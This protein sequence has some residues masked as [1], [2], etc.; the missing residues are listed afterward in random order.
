[1]DKKLYS[2]TYS[3]G[4]VYIGSV[5]KLTRVSNMFSDHIEQ[6]LSYT[7]TNENTIRFVVSDA[8][9]TS[10]SDI[11]HN[12]FQQIRDKCTQKSA[13]LVM[14]AFSG[15]ELLDSVAI[16]RN[17]HD[18]Q[19]LI[20]G[21]HTECPVRLP[22]P[23][24]SLRHIMLILYPEN[25][26]FQYQLLDLNSTSGFSIDAEK[27]CLNMWANGSAFIRLQKYT[28]FFIAPKQINW[29]QTE[30]EI[31]KQITIRNYEWSKQNRFQ[32][33]ETNNFHNILK[34]EVL[35][36][37]SREEKE[38]KSNSISILPPP[39]WLS[40]SIIRDPTVALMLKF[41]KAPQKI[42]LNEEQLERGILIGRYERCG[43]SLGEYE[44]FRSI[45]RVHCLII[46]ILG[47]K[48][49][50][51]TASTNG[52]KLMMR[53]I[54]QEELRHKTCITLGGSLEIIWTEM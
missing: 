46:S 24:I 8:P 47:K 38:D 7:P 13:E 19:T 29:Q 4:S 32:S 2:S 15:S 20:I 41:P 30:D 50:I 10:F 31:W 11:F 49:I 37:S 14:F 22:D 42:C 53:A 36:S 25:V 17:E 18:I 34:A 26:D 23:T 40:D 43:V 33:P 16:Q 21:R 54:N 6:Q 39:V 48:Y 52:T 51:D 9:S 1:M 12:S 44:L 5:K 45:S 27:N 28:F 35:P 3:Q